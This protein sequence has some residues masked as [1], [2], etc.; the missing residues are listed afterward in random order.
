M[1]LT[2]LEKLVL[3]CRDDHSQS[4]IME[5]V[6]S[7]QG[8]AFRSAIIAT[9]IAV[10]FDLIGKI[11]ELALA[12]NTV[13]SDLENRISTYIDQIHENNQQ[14]LTSALRF[15]REIIE[16]CKDALGFFDEYEANELQR[17]QEDR[18]KCAHPSFHK[19]GVAFKPSAELAR[20]H[21]K[22]AI[23]YVLSRPPLQ[24]REA[25]AQ[26]RKIVSSELFPSE[27]EK[28]AEQLKK[29]GLENP[30]EATIRACC[31]AL[32]F[33]FFDDSSTLYRSP[34]ASTAAN[35]LQHL[36]PGVAQER[37]AH[38]LEKIIKNT[39]DDEFIWTFTLLVLVDGSVDGI[40]SPEKDKILTFIETIDLQKHAFLIAAASEVSG[41]QEKL[42]ERIDEA[43]DNE[44]K[45]LIAHS[46]LHGFVV[47]NVLNS[48]Q[49]ATN[50]PMANSIFSEL[51]FPIF[52]SLTRDDVIRVIRMPEEHGTDLI[53]AFNF[54]AFVDRVKE[55]GLVDP[56]TLK[57][58]LNEVGAESLT[59]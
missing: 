27:T 19:V 54:D 45:A 11:R 2:D 21:L 34:N 58:T 55:S 41:L 12:E 56:D 39:A 48:L 52:D 6:R 3:E 36:F 57:T 26:L 20:L 18:N 23:A 17:I 25:V 9:W 5:A 38:D 29:F 16:I 49:E 7:Y 44:I 50:W 51:V 53:G 10:V 35:A 30:S 43:D 59:D 37:I 32:L 15:E 47:N 22:T 31:D 4:I 1:M 13:A 33:E 46:A 40:S 28:A 24:G 8:G 14:G 42:Q